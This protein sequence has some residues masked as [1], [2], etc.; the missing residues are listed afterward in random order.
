MSSF[1]TIPS[2]SFTGNDTTNQEKSSLMMPKK[3]GS[4]NKWLHIS[5]QDVVQPNMYTSL[6]CRKL[7]NVKFIV[8]GKSQA[9]RCHDVL[10]KHTKSKRRYGSPLEKKRSHGIL[11]YNTPN[12]M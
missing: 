10:L 8:W 3:N 6:C 5:I 1:S 2:H 11:G 4:G 9:W 7:M 12:L